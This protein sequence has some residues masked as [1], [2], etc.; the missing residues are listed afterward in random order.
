M[1]SPVKSFMQSPRLLLAACTAAITLILGILV[2]PYVI[3]AFVA[4]TAL[5]LILNDFRAGTLLVV[6]FGFT[7]LAAQEALK[8]FH[9]LLLLTILT[10]FSFLIALLT[11]KVEFK[12]P[13]EFNLLI[14]LFGTWAFL[15]GIIAID[16]KLW[17]GSVETMVRAFIVFYLIYNSISRKE[18]LLLLFKVIVLSIFLSSAISFFTSFGINAFSV[19]TI[20][21]VFSQ[22]FAGTIF[23][24][25]YF[26]MAVAASLPLA[27]VIILREKSWLIRSMWIL[28]VLFLLFSIII[29]QSRTGIFSTA[30]IFIYTMYYLGRKRKKEIFIFII[31]IATVIILLP[32]IF[33]HR[34]STFWQSITTGVR[35]DMSMM[36]RIELLNSALDVFLKNPIFGVGLNNF[37]AI[38]GRYT[39]YPMVCHNTYLEIASNLGVIGLIPFALILYKG[40]NLPG[41][42]M[43][44]SEIS[45]LAWAIRAGLLGC[46]VA[47]LFISVP[48]ILNLWIL[49]G[50][51]AAVFKI[52]AKKYET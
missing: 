14:I 21:T 47:I 6:I 29:S 2:S 51:S 28:M 42:A 27:I 43:H 18:D 19:E 16:H 1:M 12:S 49:L 35:A 40:F 23:D 46:Y 22:R 7:V 45:D 48:F 8:P 11:H 30:M 15:S 17:I 24:P 31:P 13:R 20:L 4:L 39:H 36:H 3:V 52:S 41:K 44:D 50:L 5:M 34:F 9:M 26:A 10:L 32:G 38:A 37:W 25:N 33:W